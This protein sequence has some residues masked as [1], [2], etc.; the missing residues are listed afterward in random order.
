MLM[1][2]S[3]REREENLKKKWEGVADYVPVNPSQ[4]S[5]DSVEREQEYARAQFPAEEEQ[6]RYQ[7]YREEWYRR[8]KEFDSGD[9]PLAVTCELVSTCNLACPMCYTPTEEFQSSVVGTQRMLPYE[10]VCKIIDECAELRV[11]SMLFSWRGE[12]TLYR[13][14]YN[15]VPKTFPDVL[16][17]ARRKGILEITCLTNGQGIDEKMARVIVDAEPNW[18]SFSIDS[19]GEVYNKIRT[20]KKYQGKNTNYNA[21]AVVVENIKRLIA[22]R[23]EA[24]KTRPQIRTNAVFPAIA[25]DPQAYHKFMES[26]GVGWVTVNE[27]LDFRGEDL[28]DDAIIKNWACQYPFQR[29]TV[30][31]NGSILP[32][33]GAHNEERELILGRYPGSPLKRVR[34]ADG[35]WET[36]KFPERTLYEVWHSP[37]LAEIRRLHKELRR[38]EIRACRNCRH[39]AVKHGAEWIPEDWDMEKM[40]W[41]ERVW[42]A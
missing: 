17:Y 24:G 5:F 4:Y 16:A 15:D 29:L 2:Y 8:P 18:I 12:S 9:A 42:R 28:P 33:T 19:L 20:P 34:R 22:I 25:R 41:K 23:D 10:I 7:H 6:R 21:F 32:C 36:L 35:T 37:E 39:G 11:P 40:E 3:I 26:I 38:I 27:M 30:S 13:S 14:M 31:A 1:A